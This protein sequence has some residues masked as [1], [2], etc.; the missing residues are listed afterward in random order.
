M[1][2]NYVW[3]PFMGSLRG[4]LQ[5]D[6]AIPSFKSRTNHFPS[7]ETGDCFVAN[8]APRNDGDVNGCFVWICS[9]PIYGA[10]FKLVFGFKEPDKSGNHALFEPH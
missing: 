3:H 5:A 6:E 8:N 1:L 9:C 7:P 2:F 4:G 10:Y